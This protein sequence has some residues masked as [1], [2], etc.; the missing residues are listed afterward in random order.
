MSHE[1]TGCA[2]IYVV[3]QHQHDL[4][5][6]V[7]IQRAGRLVSKYDR[8]V[9]NEAPSDGHALALTTREPL[10]EAIRERRD[11]HFCEGSHRSLAHL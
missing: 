9:T 8:P 11:A 4:F 10:G 5:A 7:R 1:D 2:R 6:S 3:T